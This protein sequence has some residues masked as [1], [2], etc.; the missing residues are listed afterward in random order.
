MHAL[1][2]S[3]QELGIYLVPSAP[4]FGI[5][6]IKRFFVSPAEDFMT[7]LQRVLP[8]P[9]WVALGLVFAGFAACWWLYVPVHELLHAFGCLATGGTVTP[10]VVSGSGSSGSSI[11]P[12]TRR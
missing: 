11:T 4:F 9:P 8:E 3:P 10:S 1:Y 7:A 6:L 12:R 5:E 2:G